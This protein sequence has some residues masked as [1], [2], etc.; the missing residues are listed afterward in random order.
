MCLEHFEL[1]CTSPNARRLLCAARRFFHDLSPMVL[2]DETSGGN[3]ISRSMA[4]PHLSRRPFAE[5]LAHSG[6]DLVMPK[7]VHRTAY[8][9]DFQFALGK[10]ETILKIFFVF[11]PFKN[12]CHESHFEV[13]FLIIL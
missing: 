10:P 9:I 13:I 7:F 1:W 3:F 2:G 11:N 8:P 5:L 12:K 4:I 6:A